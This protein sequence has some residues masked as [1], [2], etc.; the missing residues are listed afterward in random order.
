MSTI[1]AVATPLHPDSPE[2]VAL[3]A[4]IAE[5]TEERE[6]TQ[7]R[8]HEVTDWLRDAG[9]GR[10]RIPVEDGGLGVSVQEL[11]A[12]LIALAEADSNVAHI[13]RVHFAFVEQQL[14]NPDASSR[15]R[16]LELVNSGAIIGNAQSEQNDKAVAG[17]G[18]ETRAE[19]DPDGIGYRLTGVKYY[20]TGS[21]YADYIWVFAAAPDDRLAGIVIPADREGVELVD[22]W[23]GFGQRLTGTGTTRFTDVYV[24]PEEYQDWGPAGD[25]LPPTV[26]GAFLQLFLQAVTAGV[27]RAVRR[28]AAALVRRRTRSFAHAS[29]EAP[30]EDPQVLQVVGEIAA[31]AFAA[32]AIVLA[33]AARIDAALETVVDGFP[34]PDAAYEAQVA[35]AQ[36]KVAID[37]FSYATAARLFD[38]GGAS[39]T[40][41]AWQLDRHWRNVRTVSTHNPTFLKATAVGRWFVGGEAP[42]QNGFF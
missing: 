12:A 19:R 34:S 35:A 26:M 2:F 27:L 36:A 9:F 28:D 33:A 39:A 16:W 11:F 1:D 25:P 37:R 18:L 24:A 8:P 29:A 21:L 14:V 20:S 31:D 40:Q 22:D 4:R 32:E 42:P 38:A 10:L 7:T 13:L 3:L 6:R 41:A 15:A 30:A 17:R 23:D 5:G